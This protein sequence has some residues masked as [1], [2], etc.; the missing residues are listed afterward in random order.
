MLDR[1]DKVVWQQHAQCMSNS[2]NLEL[3]TSYKAGRDPVVIAQQKEIDARQKCINDD[4]AKARALI[5]VNRREIDKA[6]AV[7]A[8]KLRISQLSGEDLIAH[9]ATKHALKCANKLAK[10]EKAAGKKRTL[11]EASAL[12]AS[13]M[14]V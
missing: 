3:L 6:N 13:S 9:N 1:D 11:D 2:R 8:E 12:I 7:A 4:L 5:A 14:T 10:T